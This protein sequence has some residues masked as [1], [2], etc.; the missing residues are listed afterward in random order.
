MSDEIKVEETTSES[1]PETK[2]EESKVESE[3]K[4]DS[5]EES[6]VEVKETDKEVKETDKEEKET[7]DDKKVPYSR[8]KDVV[9]EKNKYKDLL[10]TQ[11]ES[12]GGDKKTEEKV[13]EKE[14]IK[15]DQ[16]KEILEEAR[17]VAES[18]SNEKFGQVNRQLE[19]D[20]AIAAYSDFYEFADVMKEKI[21]ETPTLGWADA[22]KLA[23]FDLSVRESFAKGKKEA[24]D[25]IEEKKAG[26]VESAGK[27][28][29]GVAD[30]GVEGLDPLARGADGK[31][32]YTVEEIEAQLPKAS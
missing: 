8:F 19:L 4:K 15:P 14:D 5:T 7:D 20:R 31:F 26:N 23:K 3:E 2:S 17:R 22:Y 25:K 16:K 9:D 30:P 21:K 13:E 32:L 28:K 11:N 18:A 29:Q 10:S 12:L 27:S 1:S 6:K 24:Y